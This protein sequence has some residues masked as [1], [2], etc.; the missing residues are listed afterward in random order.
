MATV[1]VNV[2]LPSEHLAIL[3]LLALAND[4]SVSDEIRRSIR[5]SITA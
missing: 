4:R 1:S 3:R 5:L 2:R